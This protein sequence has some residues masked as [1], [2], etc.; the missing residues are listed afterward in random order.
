[1]DITLLTE[2]EVAD[3]IGKSTKTMQRW[4][5][6]NRGPVAMKFGQTVMYTR[7]SVADWMRSRQIGPGGKPA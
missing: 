7:E 6:Q 3:F 5:A 1:M 2:R 4:R